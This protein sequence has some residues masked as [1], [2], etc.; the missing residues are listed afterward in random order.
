VILAMNHSANFN[1]RRF[2]AI[3]LAIDRQAVIQEP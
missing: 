3:T 2:E 1:A